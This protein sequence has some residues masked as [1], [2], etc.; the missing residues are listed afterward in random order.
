MK[1]VLNSFG[2]AALIKALVASALFLAMGSLSGCSDPQVYGSVGISSGYS[3]WG[4]RGYGSGIHTSISCGM[5]YGPRMQARLR[6][7]T[8]VL[9]L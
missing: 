1:R 9:L 7:F 4:G 6:P 2:A 8:S 3:S 5:S